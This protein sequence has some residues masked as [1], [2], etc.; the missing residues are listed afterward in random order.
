[1]SV[2]EAAARVA[3]RALNASRPPGSS[4]EVGRLGPTA[5]IPALVRL[6]RRFASR[7]AD[8]P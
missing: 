7:C 4:V 5:G 8:L 2:S 1:M 6:E 3:K